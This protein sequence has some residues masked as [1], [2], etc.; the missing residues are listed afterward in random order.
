MRGLCVSLLVCFSLVSGCGESLPKTVPVRG[1]VTW[2]GKPLPMGTVTFQPAESG[3]GGPLR[4]AVATIESDGTYQLS[5][6][7]THDGASPGEY[8]VAIHASTPPPMEAGSPPPK[9]LVPPKYATPATS[10]LTATVPA[11]ASE[12]LVLNFDL[13]D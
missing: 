4:P 12:E 5:T 6:F 9:W 11:D 10:G 2:Q 1:R 3:P 7:R 13:K 8:T